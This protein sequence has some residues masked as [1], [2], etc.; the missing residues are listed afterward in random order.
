MSFLASDS[1]KKC[2][3]LEDVQ[4]K[5]MSSKQMYNKET[6][7]FEALNTEVFDA[8]A[9]YHEQGHSLPLFKGDEGVVIFKVNA[10]NV[11]DLAV[12]FVKDMVVKCRV[13]LKPFEFQ[14]K[15]G[16]TPYLKIVT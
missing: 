9:T 8:L 4:L 11:D 3:W 1:N 7:Y 5:F 12:K 10:L 2:I 6:C 15:K 13:K 14:G 16:L